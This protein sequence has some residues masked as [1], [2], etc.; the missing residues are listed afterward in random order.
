MT[1]SVIG[2]LNSMIVTVTKKALPKL[3]STMERMPIGKTD[4]LT[5]RR[6]KQIAQD[7]G[8]ETYTRTLRL[9]N[10][11]DQL[12]METRPT[13]LELRVQL[14]IPFFF[15]ASHFPQKFSRITFKNHH[16]NMIV[17]ICLYLREK[18]KKSAALC[19]PEILPLLISTAQLATSRR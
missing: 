2:F 4:P 7:R 9:L 1:S 14:I 13:R 10:T 18:A 5:V 8:R 3:I 6:K 19:L 15:S 12:G 16:S 17:R 11:M